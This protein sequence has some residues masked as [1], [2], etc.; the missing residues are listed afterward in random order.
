MGNGRQKVPS[1]LNHGWLTASREIVLLTFESSSRK[2][3][4]TRFVCLCV[5]FIRPHKNRCFTNDGAFSAAATRLEFNCAIR[6]QH[7]SERDYDESGKRFSQKHSL[8][9]WRRSGEP[10]PMMRYHDAVKG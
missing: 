1:R 6:R 4:N 9:H 7:S 10:H 2:F 8:D 5:M 3:G